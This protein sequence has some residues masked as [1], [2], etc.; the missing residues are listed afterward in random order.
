[1]PLY[2]TS[3][4]IVHN[5]PTE[6]E[7]AIQGNY[8]L[9]RAKS[10]ESYAYQ[11]WYNYNYGNNTMNIPETDIHDI[12]ENW[13][14]SVKKWSVS[15][16]A[17]QDSNEYEFADMDEINTAKLE[18]VQEVK[19]QTGDVNLAGSKAN[20]ASSAI[21]SAAS[22]AATT[23]VYTLGA[24]AG[25]AFTKNLSNKV[26]KDALKKSI[27]KMAA[28]ASKEVAKEGMKEATEAIAKEG[29]KAAAKEGSKEVGEA[30]AKEAGKAG[31]KDASKAAKTSA[32][33]AVGLAAANVAKYLATK[34]NQ[35]EKKICDELQNVM[36]DSQNG[37]AA[38]QADM[39]NM[40]SELIDLTDEAATTNEEGNESIEEQKAEFDVYKATVDELIEKQKSGTPLTEDEQALLE[41]LVPLMQELGEGINVTV[42]DTG[43]TVEDIYDDM[44]TYEEGYANAQ[45]TVAE[46]TAVTDYAESVDKPAKTMCY[47]EAG[48]QGL[49]ALSAGMAAAKLMGTGPWGWAAAAVGA[50]AAASSGIFAGKQISMAKAIGTEQDMR[51][52]TQDMNLQTDE[53]REES[54]ANYDE[55]LGSVE[56]LELITPTEDEMEISEEAVAMAEGETAATG[57]AQ[58]QTG[59]SQTASGTTS[60]LG[61][62]SSGTSGSGGSS[63]ASGASG[64]A[65]PAKKDE[66]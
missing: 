55:Q 11:C 43:E 24:K 57:A 41:E 59:T 44:G 61:V 64:S 23:A 46:V 28:D 7:M 38:T 4:Y 58:G 60:T 63:G 50:A 2:I 31:S 48:S 14:S 37:L 54:V 12:T 29:G 20:C 36:T 65:N 53:L 27:N 47:V 51:K 16:Q 1:M 35:K 30:V 18:A 52:N 21:L 56:D 34:P 13:S 33:V 66:E 39:D 9:E 6:N 17:S 45:E 40:Q 32:Y 8:S 49:N 26:I 25:I 19:K 15:A 62:G 5:K 22:A 3:G 42:E 10:S